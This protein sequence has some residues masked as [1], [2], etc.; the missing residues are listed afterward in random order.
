MDLQN[1]IREVGEL[2]GGNARTDMDIKRFVNRAVMAVAQEQ[3]WTFLRD[4][5][6]YTI[7]SGTHSVSMGPNYKCLSDEK[8]PISVTYNAGDQT[9]KLP[10]LVISEEEL[11]RFM[12][13]PYIGQFTNQPTPGGYVP[14]RV[15]YM[16]RNM[17]GGDGGTWRLHIPAQ[18]TVISDSPYNVS[19]YYYPS[20]LVLGTDHNPLTDDPNLCDAVVNYAKWLKYCAVDETSKQAI[21]SKAMYD[22]HFRNANYADQRAR[23]SG[24]TLRM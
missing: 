8:S 7:L 21:A 14:I 18:F 10:V 16:K 20:P 2:P 1:L 4:V 6:A 13:F 5:R 17:T 11:Q 23:F 15:V 24:R 9:F 22:E 3:N 19:A 12:Y